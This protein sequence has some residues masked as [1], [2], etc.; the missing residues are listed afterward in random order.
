MNIAVADCPNYLRTALNKNKEILNQGSFNE[1]RG[2]SDYFSLFK[3]LDYALAHLPEGS[4]WFDGGSGSAKFFYDY[5]QKIKHGEKFQDYYG[6]RNFP[7]IEMYATGVSEPVDPTY[8]ERLKQ[9]LN[10]NNFHPLYGDYIENLN[11]SNLPKVDLITDL[12]GALSYTERPDLLLKKYLELLKPGGKIFTILKGTINGTTPDAPLYF[13]FESLLL[14]NSEGRKISTLE[15]F[16]SIKG[17]KR[18]NKI[19]SQMVRKNNVINLTFERT[20]DEIVVPE[21]ELINF[22]H[23]KPPHRFYKVKPMP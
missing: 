14:R 13:F 1:G 21:L 5:I 11:T 22:N 2:L 18:V 4:R 3:G 8:I 10:S 20:N 12:Y 15:W 23:G 9:E 19:D 17:M 16:E 6:D 7:N